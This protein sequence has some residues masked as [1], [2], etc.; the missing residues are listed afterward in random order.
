MIIAHFPTAVKPVTLATAAVGRVEGSLEVGAQEIVPARILL[1]RCAVK[2]AGLRH[3][4]QRPWLHSGIGT[5]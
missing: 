1:L 5:R 4:L 3:E 2:R